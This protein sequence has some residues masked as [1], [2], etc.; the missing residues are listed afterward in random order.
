[1]RSG[2]E[3]RPARNAD[4]IPGIVTHVRDPPEV[5]A[6]AAARVPDVKLRRREKERPLLHAVL[7][8]QPGFKESVLADM[9]ME[10][11]QRGDRAPLTSR[12]AILRELAHLVLESDAYGGLLLYRVRIAL[13]RRGVPILPKLL[14]HG[15]IVWAQI[16]IGD[17][18]LLAPGV[19]IPH[20]QVVIDGFTS[21][22]AGS[23]VRPFAAIGLR[24][25]I[26]QGPVI[27]KDVKVGT[28]AKILGPL[29]IGD[30]ARIGANAVVVKDVAADAVVVGVP[31]K[32]L[33]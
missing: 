21:I 17:P 8:Q 5:A 20:G 29:T 23:V 30:R 4:C 12:W 26:Y 9:R 25:G 13:L 10:Q 31:A 28:G 18:V 24:E 33:G 19:R 3:W 15:S 22:G 2:L 16:S 27:G 32:P 6:N 11:Q 1:M 14:H 7:R